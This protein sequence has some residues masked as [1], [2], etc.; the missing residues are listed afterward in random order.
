[1]KLALDSPLQQAAEQLS[2]CTAE[3]EVF[4]FQRTISRLEE[5]QT[6]LHWSDGDRSHSAKLKKD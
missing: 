5:M 6:E 1:M 3:E 4:A 2:L